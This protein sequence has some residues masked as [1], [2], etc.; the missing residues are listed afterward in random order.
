MCFDGGEESVAEGHAAAEDS[1][2][3]PGHAEGLYVADE[4]PHILG[5]LRSFLPFDLVL[6]RQIAGESLPGLNKFVPF[7]VQVDERGIPAESLLDC[8]PAENRSTYEEIGFQSCASRASGNSEDM[9]RRIGPHRR[10]RNEGSTR[11]KNSGCHVRVDRLCGVPIKG[12]GEAEGGV[13]EERERERV[14]RELR[15]KMKWTGGCNLVVRV[16][17]VE[18]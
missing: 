14:R 2:A 12:E 11:V 9:L 15:R 10:P 6:G 7:D 3:R 1:L 4:R 5:R 18:G 8:F 17:G 13:E 16:V